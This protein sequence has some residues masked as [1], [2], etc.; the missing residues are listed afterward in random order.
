MREWEAAKYH[1]GCRPLK[2][3][4]TYRVKERVRKQ[5]ANAFCS[6]YKV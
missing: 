6:G 4:A 3:E 5:S 2:D 1:L